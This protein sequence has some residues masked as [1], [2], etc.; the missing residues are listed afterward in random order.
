MTPDERLDAYPLLP[1]DARAAVEREVAGQPS[2]A[3][4]LAEAQALATAL[5]AAAGPVTPDDVARFV[6]DQAAGLDAP[7]AARI[8]AAMAADPALA[9][10]AEH[11]RERLAAL[12]THAEPPADQYTRL[13][14]AY[15]STPETSTAETSTRATPR[16]DRRAADRAAAGPPRTRSLGRLRRLALVAVTCGIAY[17]AAFVGST[18]ARPERDRM[19]ALDEV[20]YRTPTLRGGTT[21]APEVRLAEAMA[22]VRAA[23]RSTLGLFPRYDADALDAAA[24]QLTGVAAESAPAS[25]AS[26]EA[27][28]A[29]ARVHLQ[30]G[31]DAEAAHVLASLV[32]QGSYR[33]PEARRLL[34]WLRSRPAT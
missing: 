6:A 16:A 13:M 8:E 12:A 34:D 15:G 24:A 20:S 9:A 1:P 22:E 25:A 3:A 23:R 26:Q 14:A 31:R 27:R 17:S 21:P 11:A 2:L 18:L 7:D 5:D 32:E 29:L 28:F 4:R 30:Q 19:A 10:E 33:A